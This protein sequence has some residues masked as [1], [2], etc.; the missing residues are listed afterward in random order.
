MR[1]FEGARLAFGPTIEGGF[2][3]D[4]DLDHQLSD[5]DFPAISAEMQKIIE[6]DEPF[7]RIEQS[8]DKAVQVCR[9]LDQ[10]YK[11]EHIEGGLDEHDT[12]SFY[13]QGEFLDLCRGPHVRSAGAIGAFKL[14]SVAGKHTQCSQ[15]IILP[16][17]TGLPKSW[18]EFRPYWIKPV[19]ANFPRPMLLFLTA[20][21]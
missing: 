2:Y 17:V 14:L 3:Y 11:V 10:S 19:S 12:L 4:F 8:R 15:S 5:D 21:P 16:R 7:E 18:R 6:L 1:L 20:M 9:D 13:Q